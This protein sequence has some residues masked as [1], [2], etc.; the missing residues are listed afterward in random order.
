M[1]RSNPI[2][3]K[4]YKSKAWKQCR[5]SY[6]SSK[7]YICER[8]GKEAIICHHKIHITKDN[9]SNPM[10]TLSHSNLEA[11]CKDCHNKEH[12][13]NVENYMFDELGNIIIIER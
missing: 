4:F 1:E 5:E 3:D 11:L 8:C 13:R 10:I 2:V 7:F 6:M 12:F 9:I